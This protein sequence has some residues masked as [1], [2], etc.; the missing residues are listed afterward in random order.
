[1][2]EIPHGPSRHKIVR[3]CCNKPIEMFEISSTA[4][5]L[6][7]KDYLNRAR[8]VLDFRFTACTTA[9]KEG[10]PCNKKKE[11]CDLGLI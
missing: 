1:M 10:A 8:K 2:A 3:E 6:P 7:G 9:L 5:G 4:M 11:R